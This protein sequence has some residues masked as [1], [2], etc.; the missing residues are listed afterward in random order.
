MKRL[1]T[2]M[3]GAF[4]VLMV[5]A[6][7]AHAV[8]YSYCHYSLNGGGSLAPDADIYNYAVNHGVQTT[9]SEG[10]SGGDGTYT[11]YETVRMYR[12]GSVWRVKFYCSGSG[13]TY[14]DGRVY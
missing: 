1:L 3:F 7:M 10:M 5:W 14:A 2:A 12:N 6:A 9:Y 4:A 11:V 13:S 8:S